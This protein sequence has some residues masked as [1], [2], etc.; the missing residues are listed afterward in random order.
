M[1]TDDRLRPVGLL[2][3]QLLRYAVHA[4]GVYLLAHGY[5]ATQSDVETLVGLVLTAVPIVWDMRREIRWNNLV[6]YLKG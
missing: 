2:A 6:Q 5:L 4:G 1:L 3:L